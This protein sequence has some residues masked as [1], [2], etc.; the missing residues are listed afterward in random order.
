MAWGTKWE[1]VECPVLTFMLIRNTLVQGS[2]AGTGEKIT[3]RETFGSGINLGL[4]KKCYCWKILGLGKIVG[5]EKN[6]GPGKM[7][8][9]GNILS[10]G[11]FLEHKKISGPGKNVWSSKK[12]WVK[13]KF[14]GPKKNLGPG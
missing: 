12:M 14:G 13:E 7:L 2:G 6:V 11:K 5:P 9:P 8:G 1:H 4:E 10:L 3:V